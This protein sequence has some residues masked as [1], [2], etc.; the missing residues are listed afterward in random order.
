VYEHGV[1]VVAFLCE[2][3]GSYYDDQVHL[4]LCRRHLQLPSP[5]VA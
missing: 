2:L 1:L 4:L 3:P 5:G